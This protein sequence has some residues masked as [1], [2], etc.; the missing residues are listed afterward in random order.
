VV[1]GSG[2]VVLLVALL[3][4]CSD[5]RDDGGPGDGKL[6][7][8]A[9]FYPLL[10]AAGAV[11]GDQVEVTNLTPAGAEPHDIELSPRQLDRVADADLL[12]YLGGGFQPAVEDA[13]GRSP[14]AVDVRA[15]LTGAAPGDPHVWLDP[16]LFSQ[17][18]D[19]IRSALSEVDP[20]GADAYRS[21]AD[22]YRSRL[23]EL[24]AE[25]RAGLADCDRRTIVTTHE[26]F[27][28]LVRRYDLEQ[29][30]ISGLA[31]DAEPDPR[32]LA[33]LADVVRQRG[34]TTIFTEK[35]VSPRVAETLAR[36]TGVRTAVVDTIEGDEG[37]GDYFSRMRENLAT[38]RAALGCR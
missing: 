16:S 36:E 2:V 27:G 23:G 35:L 18:L 8:V 7:V 11:G 9:S 13:A 20:P 26:A 17:V 19:G 5:G 38:L 25:F 30:A 3:V 33:E 6:A 24:D 14:K 28:Y 1:R 29:L 15:G 37:E 31:P 4:G 32:R 10:D 22:A 21:G 12:L 34:V